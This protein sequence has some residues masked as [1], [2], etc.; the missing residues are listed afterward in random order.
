LHDAAERN[1]VG[2]SRVIFDNEYVPK[3]YD[4]KRGRF[5]EQAIPFMKGEPWIRHDEHYHLD[6]AVPCRPMPG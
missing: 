4:T 1:G 6:F 5:V 3:L 2:I